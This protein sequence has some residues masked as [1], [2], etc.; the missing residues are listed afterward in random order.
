MSVTSESAPRGDLL[1][2]N[3]IRMSFLER[4][5]LVEGYPA[6]A[7]GR[8]NANNREN[9]VFGMSLIGGFACSTLNDLLWVI[10]IRIPFLEHCWLDEGYPALA[11]GQ[12]NTVLKSK[13][14]FNQNI[15]YQYKTFKRHA[16][17]TLLRRA[18]N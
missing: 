14:R 16:H 9:A 17:S 2:V 5:W 8:Q 6:L 15:I 11:I 4:R 10:K 1:W 7:N 18:A 13:R 3:K 12:W